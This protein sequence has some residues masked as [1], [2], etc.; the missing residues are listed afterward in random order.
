[1]KRIAIPLVLV[2]TFTGNISCK[3]CQTC[4]TITTQSVMGIDQSVSV[5]EEYCGKDYDNAPQEGT[6]TNNVSG[7]TQEVT[8]SCQ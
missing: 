6:V 4:T 8:I 7:V 3:K 5:S 2:L 1:M